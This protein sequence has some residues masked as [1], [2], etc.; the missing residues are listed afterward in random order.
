[1]LGERKYSKHQMN[2]Y[3]IFGS[4]STNRSQKLI[5]AP[6][7]PVIPVIQP[8]ITADSAECNEL[9]VSSCCVFVCCAPTVLAESLSLLVLTFPKHFHCL[10]Y[11]MTFAVHIVCYD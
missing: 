1:M 9:A 10:I 2:F 7:K 11:F 5:P 4:A 6:V 3:V 8:W